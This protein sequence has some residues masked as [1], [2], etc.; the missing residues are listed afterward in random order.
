MVTGALDLALTFSSVWPL[1]ATP[2]GRRAQGG[3]GRRAAV[4]RSALDDGYVDPRVPRY[5]MSC[6]PSRQSSMA[7]ATR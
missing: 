3:H 1:P 2:H 7:S 6:D 5:R 4:A